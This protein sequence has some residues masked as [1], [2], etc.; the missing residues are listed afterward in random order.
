MNCMDH[1][2]SIAEEIGYSGDPRHLPCAF[3]V[4]MHGYKEEFNN[5]RNLRGGDF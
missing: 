2:A 5:T 3:F 1:L 4:T